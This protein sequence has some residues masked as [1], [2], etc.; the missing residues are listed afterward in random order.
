MSRQH[1]LMIG[2][3]SANAFLFGDNERRRTAR[4]K[5]FRGRSKRAGAASITT[6][7]PEA[8]ADTRWVDRR[9]MKRAR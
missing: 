5:V 2:E 7:E 4:A 3:P 8:P 9:V 6:T 1:V